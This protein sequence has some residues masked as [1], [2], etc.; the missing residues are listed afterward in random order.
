M[1]NPMVI[2]GGMGVAVSN[3]RLA[4]S[5]SQQGQLGVVSGTFLDGILTR[6]LQ[7]GDLTGDTRQAL[8]HFPLPDMA[9]R[10]IDSYYIPGGRLANQPYKAVAMHTLNSPR[11]LIELTVVANFVE[12]FLA[13]YGHKGVVGINYLTKIELPILPSLYGAMLAGVDYVLMGAG[14][15]KAIPGIL[16]K[17]SRNERATMSINVEGAQ[18]D[19]VFETVFDPKEFGFHNIRSMKR[20]FFIAIVSSST[21]A[22]ALSKRSHVNGFVVEHHTAGGHN[23]PPRGELKVDLTGEPLYGAKDECNLAEMRKIGLPFWLAGSYGSPEQLKSAQKQGAQGIQVGTAFAFC[24]ESGISTDIKQAVINKVIS[25]DTSSYTDILASASG[26]PFK[27]VKLEGSLSERKLY[28]A[29]PRL[30]DLGY[31]RTPFKKSDGV[32]GFRCPAEPIDDYLH[33]GGNLIDTIGKKCLCNGLTST[34]GY[35]QIQKCGYRELPLVTAGK[36]LM[37]IKRCLSGKNS[38]S[39]ADVLNYLLGPVSTGSNQLNLAT[40]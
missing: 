20:P 27:V 4:R 1:N 35:A 8:T 28:E 11:S 39:A 6:R 23:A 17:C 31:L 16:D 13:K 36:D 18:S 3:Y 32:V 29:R 19:E 33:K 38:Y 34:V 26:Y 25:D 15:P 22:W 12:V 5:V 40:G 9:Q 21:L 10:I 2:Q 7:D 14:I 24:N 37:S 30:C